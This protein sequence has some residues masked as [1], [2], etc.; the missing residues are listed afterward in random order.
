MHQ[1]V[2]ASPTGLA[3]YR[4]EPFGLGLSALIPNAISFSTGDPRGLRSG[5]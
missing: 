1:G 3:G 5:G 4:P 2:S